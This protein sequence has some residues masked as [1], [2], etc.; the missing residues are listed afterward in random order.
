MSAQMIVTG[1]LS[2]MES[3]K[4]KTPATA[5]APNATCESP[6]PM[7]ESRFNTSGTPRRAAESEISTPATSAFLTNGKLE[8]GDA[9]LKLN[10]YLA[11]VAATVMIGLVRDIGCRENLESEQ[12]GSAH[13]GEKPSR[14]LAYPP[15]LSESQHVR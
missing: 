13:G 3:A 8:I 1:R 9:L 15:E 14:S 5:I 6:S 11:V 4:F 2:D 10:A 7:N 12:Q